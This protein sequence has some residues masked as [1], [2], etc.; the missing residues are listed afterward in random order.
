MKNIKKIAALLLALSIMLCAFSLTACNTDGAQENTA[1]SVTLVVKGSEE[2]TFTVS[3][4]GLTVDKGLLSI[5]DS[6]KAEGKLDYGITGTFLDY[7]GE[8]KNDYDKG[9]YIYVYTSI[10]ADHDV[11]VMRHSITYNGR[12]LVSAGIGAAEMT[13]KDGAIFYVAPHT[14]TW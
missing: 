10:E 1:G 14:P 4:D 12:E 2:K 8:V 3:L 9:E 13:V 5:F 6:L 11:S 7:V